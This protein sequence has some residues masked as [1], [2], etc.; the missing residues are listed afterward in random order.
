VVTGEWSVSTA[1]S[2]AARSS[3]SGTLA[4]MLTQYLMFIVLCIEGI[5]LVRLL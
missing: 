5:L 2:P 4:K 3:N 1:A